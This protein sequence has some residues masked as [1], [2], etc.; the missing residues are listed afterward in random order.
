[1]VQL[2]QAVAKM[3]T[4]CNKGLCRLILYKLDSFPYSASVMFV[5]NNVD[6]LDVLIRKSLHGFD[7]HLLTC[8][9]SITKCLSDCFLF[10]ESPYMKRY[11]DTVYNFS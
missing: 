11:I 6:S 5:A 1:M 2:K 9:N 8:D 7:T 4:A 3:R 10:Y